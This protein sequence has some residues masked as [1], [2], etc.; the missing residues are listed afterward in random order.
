MFERRVLTG[1]MLSMTLALLVAMLPTL[2]LA[3]RGS[4]PGGPEP[5]AVG[6]VTITGNPLTIHVAA[7]TSIQ[8]FYA[9]KPDGQVYP[10]DYDEA[11]SGAL[12]WWGPPGVPPL[13]YG[14]NW[15]LHDVSSGNPVIPWLPIAQ[16]TVGGSGN[17]A[18]PWKLTTEVW[19]AGLDI[20]QWIRYVDGD[21][22]FR[23]MYT[24]SALQSSAP[25]AFTFFHAA[26]LWPDD[27]NSG[28]GY[29][30]PAAGAVGAWNQ[31]KTF[32]EYFVPVLEDLGSAMPPASHYQEAGYQLIWNNIGTDGITQGPGF[33]DTVRATPFHNS[34]SGLQWDL[35]LPGVPPPN[36][37]IEFGVDWCFL[38]AEEPPPPEFVPEPGSVILLATGLMGLAGYAGLRVRKR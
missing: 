13:V 24:V 16:S 3:D 37:F 21:S 15:G 35:N 10:P 6:H 12:M 27:S 29:Y 25:E 22:C 28:Y 19:A 18:D 7:D 33:D 4:T 34:G 32:L 23:V 20:F 26:D 5:Q 11:D 30:D 17:A 9:G 2:A 8:V 36:N 1:L 38:E 14:P 31:G